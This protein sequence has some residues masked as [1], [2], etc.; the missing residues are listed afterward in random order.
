MPA[1]RRRERGG[2]W[3]AKEEKGGIEVEAADFPS[4]TKASKRKL[5]TSLCPFLSAIPARTRNARVREA[6]NK[7]GRVCLLIQ[8]KLTT[9]FIIH[10][11]THLRQIEGRETLDCA[12]LPGVVDA[13]AQLQPLHGAHGQPGQH[14]CGVE[15]ARGDLR[16]SASPH[17]EG[18]GR[19]RQLSARSVAAD[20]QRLQ[21]DEQVQIFCSSPRRSS[22]T[23]DPSPTHHKRRGE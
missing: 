4:I 7:E 22:L 5:P 13:T 23:K 21:E 12:G 3:E 19:L 18:G 8:Y 15:G 16:V 9:V 1:K 2:G 6:K 17:Q 20:D 14:G 11:M 10:A